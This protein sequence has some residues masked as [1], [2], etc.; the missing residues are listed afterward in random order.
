MD[1]GDGGIAH[2]IPMSGLQRQ[3]PD[4]AIDLTCIPANTCHRTQL[5]CIGAGF[6]NEALGEFAERLAGW[7]RLK[8]F[9]AM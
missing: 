8:S 6:C 3:E 9:T 2:A 1:D 7:T 5:R 4:D